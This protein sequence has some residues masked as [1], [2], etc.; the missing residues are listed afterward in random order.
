M[1]P[2]A[3]QS[4]GDRRLSRERRPAAA[5]NDGVG[6]RLVH[7]GRDG[8][9]GIVNPPVWRASTILFGTLGDL[10]A[11]LRAPDA[12]LFYGRRGT[13]TQWALED[14]LSGLEPGAAGTKLYP[15]GVAA[16]AT[17][18]LSVLS[19]GDH[20]LVCDSAYDPTR[21]FAD[22]LL[23]RL[24]I[25]ASYY[26]PGIGSGI[27]ALI[28][29]ETRAILIESPG[30]LTFEVEDVPAI[31]AIARAHGIATIADNTWATPL[32]FQ[33]IAHG[34]DLSVQ[35]L[36]KYVGGHS[37]VMMGSVTAA[38]SH[39]ARLKT[40]T[41]RLGQ[42]VS[43]DDAALILRGLRT[44]ALRLDRHEASALAVARWLQGHRLVAQVLH[45][46][47]PGSP[48]HEL[49]RR[50]F[51]GATGLFAFVLKAG[52]RADTAALLDELRHFGI[53]F[54]WGGYESLAIPADFRGCRT[55]VPPAFPGPVI[56]VSIGLEDADDLIADLAAGLDRYAARLADDGSH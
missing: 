1:G 32:R 16:I 47:L 54:S 2:V 56:R 52:T 45:P 27:A 26:P 34:C 44:L 8:H 29:P 42:T 19:A 22:G 48:G 36:T 5:S 6:T 23:D 39:W 11:A 43:P 38:P 24:G 40:A 33:P 28:R 20:L 12:G 37:D 25:T 14:A 7:A 21:A 17:A 10:D 35:A 3:D 15:S 9:D 46:A 13:P 50:D 49:F 30:S 4:G 18:L 51:A 53:G 41:Y 31:T 55:A